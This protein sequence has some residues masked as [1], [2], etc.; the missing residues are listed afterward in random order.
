MEHLKNRQI[1]NFIIRFYPTYEISS[2]WKEILCFT[3]PADFRW[4]NCPQNSHCSRAYCRIECRM[5][6]GVEC[7]DIMWGGKIKFKIE[8]FFLTFYIQ[9]ANYKIK[10]KIIGMNF[11]TAEQDYFI[12]FH[13]ITRNHLSVW[14]FFFLSQTFFPSSL[15][16]FLLSSFYTLLALSF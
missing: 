2:K 1:S 14:I 3:R 6:S 9:N 13:C 16:F 8:K 7:F 11:F 4:N 12:P 10:Q 5:P 15:L